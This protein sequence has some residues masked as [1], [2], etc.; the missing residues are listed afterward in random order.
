[1]PDFNPCRGNAQD[2]NLSY[3]PSDEDEDQ[4]GQDEDMQHI[5]PH[6]RNCAKL[7]AAAKEV[8][9]CVTDDW[10][11]LSNFQPD[12]GAP[13]GFLV[14]RQSVT[15]QA[16]ADN[17]QEGAKHRSPKSSVSAFCM[18]PKGRHERGGR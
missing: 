15:C 5:E 4:N 11:A 9:D 10:D 8:G 3:V 18:R 2:M 16:E 14:P 1:V 12:S 17:A 6:Q 13:I 7:F